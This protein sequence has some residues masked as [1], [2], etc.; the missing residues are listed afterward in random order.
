M[1]PSVPQ[2]VILLLIIVL[3]VSIGLALFGPIAKKAG[4]PIWLSLLMMVPVFNIATVW[5]FAFIE[6]P[7]EKKA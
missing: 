1:I 4:F 6:W 2:L 3:V 7:A 5:I